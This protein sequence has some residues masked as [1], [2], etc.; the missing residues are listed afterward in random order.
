M[1]VHGHQFALKWLSR[2]RVPWVLLALA[3]MFASAYSAMRWLGVVGAISAWIGLAEYEGEIPKLQAQAEVWTWL[4]VSLPF[5]AAFVLGLGRNPPTLS[6]RESSRVSLMYTAESRSEK[7]TTPILR[8][9]GR[10]A[11][12]ILG[13]FGCVLCLFLITLLVYKLGIHTGLTR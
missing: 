6:T 11:I 3:I 10:L 4:A 9:A 8:Y 1:Q 2:S 12:S 5:V 7:W 13:T